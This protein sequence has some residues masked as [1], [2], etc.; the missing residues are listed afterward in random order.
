M[1]YEPFERHVIHKLWR[2][3][4]KEKCQGCEIWFDRRDLYQGHCF[5]CH[6]E[7]AEFGDLGPQEETRK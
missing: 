5:Y 3:A 2:E 1:R 6:S 4:Q 7:L